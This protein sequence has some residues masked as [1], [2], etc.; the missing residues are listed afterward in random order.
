MIIGNEIATLGS[1][2]ENVFLS[3]ETSML[4]LLKLNQF[5]SIAF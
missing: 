2:K 5:Y 1:I 3:S 4:C